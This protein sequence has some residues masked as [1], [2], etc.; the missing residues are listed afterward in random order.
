MLPTLIEVLDLKVPELKYPIQGASFAD[1]LLDLGGEGHEYIVSES[2]SQATV[3]TENYKLGIMVDPTGLYPDRDYRDFG[4][5]FFDRTRDPYE[6][7]NRIDD[8]EYQAVIEKL[9]GYYEE[10][11]QNTPATGRNELIEKHRNQ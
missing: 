1:I 3:I 11:V 6:L 5:M 8:P 2:W 10:Y 7:E 4:D 9:M